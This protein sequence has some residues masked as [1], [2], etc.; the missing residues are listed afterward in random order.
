E[1]SDGLYTSIYRPLGIR[2]AVSTF[3]SLTDYGEGNLLSLLLL[4]HLSN[5]GA[6]SFQFIPCGF[7][8]NY[9]SNSDPPYSVYLA[10]FISLCALSVPHLFG[11]TFPLPPYVFNPLS[12]PTFFSHSVFT[13]FCLCTRLTDES[14]FLLFL[15]TYELIFCGRLS[16]STSFIP[17]SPCALLPPCSVCL[18]CPTSR[19]VE[20]PVKPA[21]QPL[22][23]STFSIAS[24]CR[25]LTPFPPFTLVIQP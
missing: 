21:R 14:L 25:F 7:Y 24:S 19:P 6:W 1:R 17:H 18:Y 22:H 16:C 15:F 10:S 4:T 20:L 5:R 13:L 2:P 8:P 12:P 23:S 9:T 11:L 3:L